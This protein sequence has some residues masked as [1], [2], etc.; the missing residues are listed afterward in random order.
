MAMK[1]KF[2]GL[3]MAAAM[4]IP[5]TT[6]YA[7]P[8]YGTVQWNDN[9]EKNHTVTVTGT[10]T[11]NQGQAPNGKLQVELPTAMAFIVDK[12]NKIEAASYNV[13]NNSQLKVSLAVDSFSESDETSGIK[14]VKDLSGDAKRSEVKLLLTGNTGKSVVLADMK[15]VTQPSEDLLTVDPGATGTMILSGTAGKRELEGQD[16]QNGI[17][18]TFNLVFKLK[19]VTE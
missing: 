14:V 7:A 16:N 13:K 12:D 19:K 3:A 6:A 10:V 5:A 9:E 2:L 8:G 4:V 17:E 11:N 15:N 18:E 1:K